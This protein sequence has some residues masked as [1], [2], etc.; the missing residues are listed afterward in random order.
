[1]KVGVQLKVTLNEILKLESFQEVTVAAGYNGL[2]NHIENVYVME[3]PDISAYV[4]QGGLLFTTLYP[5]VDDPSA[6]ENFI[7]ELK[8]LG[9]AGVAIKVGRYIQEIP[10]YMLKQ[11]DE[12]SFPLLR[13]PSSSNFSLLSNDIL[14]E[15]LGKKTKE[16]EFRESISSKLHTLLLSG[17]DIK[18]LLSYVS[19]VT[20]MDIV[21]ISEQ[22]KYI[23]SSRYKDSVDFSIIDNS[24]YSKSIKSAD[25]SD[26][27]PCIQFEGDLYLRKD[28]MIQPIDA[29]EKVLG[30]LILIKNDKK[31]KLEHL[32]IIIEQAI[33]LLAF[34]LQNRQ[35]LIQKER[36][37]LDNFI[38][39]IINENY[40]FQSELIE[41]AKV[42]KWNFHFPNTIMLIEISNKFGDNKI[43]NH[44]K[45]I[46]S[47]IISEEIARSCE[48]PAENCKVALH[49]NRI[50]CFISIAL[51]ND[52]SSKIKKASEQILQRLSSYGAIKI[53]I[54]NKIYSIEE[55]KTAY[56]D[57]VLVQNVYKE[58]Y[59]SQSF[60]EFYQ[61]IGIFRLFHLID[62][63]EYLHKYVDE[64]LGHVIMSD[65]KNDM[66]LIQT[67]KVLIR[68]N[69]NV[70]K[71][72]DEL[73]IHYNSLRYRI[74]K[75]K[76][77]GIEI[78]D[79]N[80]MIE[81][82]VACQLL[83]YLNAT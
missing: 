3:V 26:A 6:M 9:L 32:D 41:K 15:L 50:I 55:I 65:E 40:K 62:D 46:D 4:D 14:T 83:S 12:L 80:E 56:E 43:V 51:V 29:G 68:N 24:F 79:G 28:V 20:S 39:D 8:K 5:I 59:E 49:D 11:A 72:A 78:K 53:S 22:L 10:T 27:A 66:E 25:Y 18:D 71:S 77:L 21:I 37:Y 69:M 81:I 76:E 74:G 82:A 36:T 16:L 57:A 73:Y 75:L 44:Y 13:L 45:A 23:E 64:K 38:R 2:N 34:L 35:S 7:P 31:G 1:L 48:I 17:A 61:N 30:Y 63:K 67:L 19:V 52:L 33:I 70:K 58:V 54:S 47:G 42:F 60:I